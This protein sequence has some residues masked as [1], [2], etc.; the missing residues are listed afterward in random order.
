MELTSHEKLRQTFQEEGA[1]TT[2]PRG[3]KGLAIQ[4]V[5]WHLDGW[6]T[7]PQRE[8]QGQRE[9]G[10]RSRWALAATE[11]LRF[12]FSEFS[13]KPLQGCKQQRDGILKKTEVA[14]W[15]VDCKMGTGKQRY[16]VQ[17]AIIA[18]ER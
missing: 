2:R 13:G 15:R 10:A 16:R 17:A 5:E 6:D 8:R 1:M 7:V 4:G 11:Q 18:Q 3:R 9:A 14:K 12:F